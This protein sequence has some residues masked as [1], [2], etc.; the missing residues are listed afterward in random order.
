[1]VQKEIFL[2]KVYTLL[3]YAKFRTF[4]CATR[5]RLGIYHQSRNE[6]L[7]VSFIWANYFRGIKIQ[8]QPHNI[9]N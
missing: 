2:H 8:T 1:M 3:Y 5:Y 4:S 7:T 6:Q 9:T